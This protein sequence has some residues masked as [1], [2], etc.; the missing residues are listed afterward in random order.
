M[1]RVQPFRNKGL[2]FLRKRNKWVRHFRIHDEPVV[3][4]HFDVIVVWECESNEWIADILPEISSLQTIVLLQ[5]NDIS[6]SNRPE[7]NLQVPDTNIEIV[8]ITLPNEGNHWA[9]GTSMQS[10]RN[11]ESNAAAVNKLIPLGLQKQ[12][13]FLP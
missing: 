4:E 2:R 13:L 8:Y 5:K 6:D 1:D 3:D 12:A 10:A 11:Y 9:V 7:C